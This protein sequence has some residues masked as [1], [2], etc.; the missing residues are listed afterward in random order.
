MRFVIS[1]SC[2]KD[3]T[4][5]LHEMQYTG[6][7]PVCAMVSVSKDTNRSLFHG[8]DISMLKCYEEALEIPFLY[9]YSDSNDYE[10]PI[11]DSL[12][13]AKEMGAE[14]AVYGDIDS[15]ENRIWRENHTSPAG[16]DSIFPLWQRSREELLNKMIETG[17]H[18]VIKSIQNTILPE[19]LLGKEIT[20]ETIKIIQSC[21][22]DICGENGEYH[23]LVTD[24]PV[25]KK[26]LNFK[27]GNILR[28]GDFSV[29]DIK[30]D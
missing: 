30:A 6:H 12:R 23:T 14:A 17:Y 29:M 8:A 24:G 7:E 21:G 27:K 28:F 18:C 16:L 1:Y 26:P 10:Q 15:T 4:L 25:F 3:S 22:A 13:K 5:A 9:C 11:I 20:A 19:T 2:G